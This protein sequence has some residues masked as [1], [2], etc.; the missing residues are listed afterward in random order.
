MPQPSLWIRLLA[1]VALAWLLGLGAGAAQDGPPAEAP[2]QVK[3]FVELLDDPGVRSWL[4]AQL[5]E[6]VPAGHEPAEIEP[7]GFE[8]FGISTLERW[9]QH[10]ERITAALPNL[11]TEI[12][13]AIRRLGDEVSVW[14]LLSIMPL[15]AGFVGAGLVAEG[16]FLRATRRLRRRVLHASEATVGARIRKVGLRLVLAL[17]SVVIFAAASLGAFLLFDWP[18]LFRT[19]IG[20]FLFAFLLLRLG[21]VIGRVLLQPALPQLRIVPIDT[22]DARFW[23]IR[24]VALLAVFSIGWASATSLRMLG[25]D[26]AAVAIVAYLFGLGLVAIAIEAILNRRRD[27]L[28]DAAADGDLSDMPSTVPTILAIIYVV[29]LYLMWL[30]SAMRLFW[31]TLVVGV[32]VGAVRVT[33]QAVNNLLRPVGSEASRE[34]GP[35]SITAA[36]VE[37]GARALLIV[38]AAAVLAWAWA[39]DLSA[40]ARG[41]SGI[42]PAA[43][44]LISVV[45]IGLLADFGW[46][47]A[48]TAIDVHIHR[49]QNGEAADAEEARRRA[50]LRTLLPIIRNVLFITVLVTAALMALAAL[51]VQIGPLIA[52]AGVVGVAIGFGSQTLVKDIISGVFFLFDDAFRV[53]E[54]IVSG[55]YK[56]TVESFSIRSIKLR[57]QRG[58]LFTVPF[59]SLGAIQNMSRDWVIDKLMINVTYDTDLERMRKVVK[60]VGKTLQAD[61]ELAPSIIEPLKMQGVQQMGDFAMQVAL[62]MMCKPGQQFIVRRRA[63]ALLMKAFAEN[64]IQVALPT[65]TVAGGDIGPAA[66][67]HAIDLSPRLEAAE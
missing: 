64:A 63:Y 43:G 56:G 53:G 25:I 35:P 27:A 1:A 13:A 3:A 49:S 33:Q 19:V 5:A 4:K 59:G 65:V 15:I 2:P 67:K 54:Y 34:P 10:R 55:S 38:I 11:P 29:S 48:R 66:A 62:K 47:V 23:F 14:G 20:R 37:R 57:H 28:A 36:L 30:Q 32:L 24:W 40:V 26:P 21:L 52:G 60:Q 6:P 41:E 8:A 39:I 58:P 18:P 9:Q 45:L 51:G 42:G 50:R 7:A 61:P 44:A 12:A 46:H 17:V 16:L 31:L 22:T